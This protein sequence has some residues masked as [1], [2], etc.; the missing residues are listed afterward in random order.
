MVRWWS[1]VCRVRGPIDGYL[2]RVIL[3]EDASVRSGTGTKL[4]AQSGVVTIRM[5]LADRDGHSTASCAGIAGLL[6]RTS[7]GEH[8]NE[9]LSIAAGT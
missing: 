1:P 5:P 7:V 9:L 2:G 4:P 8:F 6:H 3:A